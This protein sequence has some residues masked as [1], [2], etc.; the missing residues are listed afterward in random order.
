M[1]TGMIRSSGAIAPPDVRGA[2]EMEWSTISGASPESLEVGGP[3]VEGLRSWDADR[4]YSRVITTVPGAREPASGAGAGAPG[5]E[6][7]DDW[8]DLFNFRGSPMP[9]LLLFALAMLGF[10]Q[11]GASARVGPARAS[12][13]VG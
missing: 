6:L 10:A 2:G 4:G 13:S 3:Y 7:I 9:W 5:V 11:L 8:R 12:A 1:P